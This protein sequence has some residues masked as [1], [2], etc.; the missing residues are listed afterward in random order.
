MK[1]FQMRGYFKTWGT[2]LGYSIGVPV[3][4]PLKKYRPEQITVK[5]LKAD[6]RCKWEEIAKMYQKA[7]NIGLYKERVL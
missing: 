3:G 1:L 5:K 2:P 6:I 7:T 4:V